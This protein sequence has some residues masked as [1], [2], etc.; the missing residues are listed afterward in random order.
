LGS[1]NLCIR[2]IVFDGG[3]DGMVNGFPLRLDPIPVGMKLQEVATFIGRMYS[4]APSSREYRLAWYGDE[5]WLS[6]L[7][8]GTQS[9]MQ[10]HLLIAVPDDVVQFQSFQLWNVAALGLAKSAGLGDFRKGA[11]TRNVFII[12]GRD[13]SALR[14]LASTVERLGYSPQILSRL[15]VRGGETLIESL[16]RLLPNAALVVALFTP[17]DEGRLA[18]R[19]EPLRPRVR[20]NVLVEAGFALIQ[21]R[22]DAII[23]ALGDTEIP[24][25]FAG[26]RRIEAAGWGY[27]VEQQLADAMTAKV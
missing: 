4:D 15:P 9:A 3:A 17:D 13:D 10:E 12:H 21:R 2:A 22:S 5:T 27:S 8:V 16:E 7:A 26:I 24:S 14:Q 1:A 11:P 20:Q 19:S 18:G 25:D 23:V 6:S